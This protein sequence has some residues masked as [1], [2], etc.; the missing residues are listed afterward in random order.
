MQ[1]NINFCN[2]SFGFMMV[3]KYVDVDNFVN[4]YC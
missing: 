2:F 3:K 1:L 4:D